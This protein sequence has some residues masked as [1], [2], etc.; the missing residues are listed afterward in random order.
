MT[1]YRLVFVNQLF[2]REHTNFDRE[3]PVSSRKGM[4]LS[5]FKEKPLEEI[6]GKTSKGLERVCPC[7]GKTFLLPTF[8]AYV[9]KR[10]GGKRDHYCSYSCFLKGKQK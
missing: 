10:K 2:S 9:I 6:K 5:F 1:E 4:E 3:K 8:N 7:C